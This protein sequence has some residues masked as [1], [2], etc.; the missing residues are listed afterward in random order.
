[1][2]FKSQSKFSISSLTHFA[3]CNHTNYFPLPIEQNPPNPPQQDT[4]VPHMPRK[5]TLRQETPGPSGTQWSEDLSCPKQK[6]IPFLIL[7]FDSSELTLPPFVEPSQHNEPPIPGPSP[8][9]EPHED[10]SACEPEP[11]VAP[12]HSLEEPFD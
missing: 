2:G 9:S 3:S 6:A 5:Q 8:S 11:N 12:T 4:P 1:M 7:A 10:F